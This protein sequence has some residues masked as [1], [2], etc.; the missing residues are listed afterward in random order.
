[1]EPSF[2][3]YVR[4]DVQVAACVFE[5]RNRE[6]ELILSQKDVKLNRQNGISNA[7]PQI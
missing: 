2:L 3:G 7:F 4:E 1:M 6:A 5:I